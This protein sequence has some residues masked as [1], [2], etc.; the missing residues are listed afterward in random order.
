MGL[1]REPKRCNL[2]SFLLEQEVVC[3]RMER[4]THPETKDGQEW[5]RI[6]LV[7]CGL[8]EDHREKCG[9]CE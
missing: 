2:A 1:V 8:R 4:V 7:L 6:A 9:K 5:G 3:R